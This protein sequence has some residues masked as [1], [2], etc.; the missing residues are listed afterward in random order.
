MRPVGEFVQLVEAG[1]DAHH[2][3]AAVAGG[4]DLVHRGLHDVLQDD[5]VLGGPALGDGIDLS[6]GLVDEVFDFAVLAVAQLDDLGAGVDQAPEDG[7]LGH[8]LGVVAGVGRGGNGLD[9]LVEVG[10]PADPVDLAALGQLVETVTAS[11]GSP[12]P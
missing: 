5:V 2:A 10:G 12:R 6:L 9:E 1:G 3:F 7:T 11:A 8:D 4:L